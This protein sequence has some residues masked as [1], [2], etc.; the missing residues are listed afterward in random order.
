MDMISREKGDDGKDRRSQAQASAFG[1][2][3]EFVVVRR[4]YAGE[5][6]GEVKTSGVSAS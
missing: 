5:T 6:R 1:M 2:D 3:G 4:S